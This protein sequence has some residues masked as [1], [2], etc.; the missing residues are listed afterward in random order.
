MGSYFS[1]QKARKRQ[2]ARSGAEFTSDASW[3]FQIAGQWRKR[4]S[5]SLAGAPIY[6]NLKIDLLPFLQVDQA[7]PFHGIDPEVDVEPAVNWSDIAVAFPSVE[8][9]YGSGSHRDPSREYP[10]GR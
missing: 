10:I 4:P 5:E 1:R 7:G 6:H 2:H 3:L 8:P 9:F